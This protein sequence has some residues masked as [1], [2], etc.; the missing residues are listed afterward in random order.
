MSGREI[1]RFE[2]IEF[3]YESPYVPK[4]VRGF[5][6]DAKVQHLEGKECQWVCTLTYMSLLRCP[7]PIF[8]E[9]IIHALE[10]GN[11]IMQVFKFAQ[12]F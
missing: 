4:S 8:C 9:I 7:M 11:S 3:A 2:K 6:S 12:D 1:M 5:F 10:H